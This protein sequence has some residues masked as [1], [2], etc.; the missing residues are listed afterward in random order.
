MFEVLIAI[1]VFLLLLLAGV[2]VAYASIAGAVAGLAI[3]GLLPME[4]LAQQAYVPTSSY[5]MLAIPFFILTADLL[6]SGRLGKQVIA[7]ATRIVGRFR[8]GVGMTTV[9]TNAVFAGVSGSAVADATGLGKIM[10]PW[11][12]RLGFPASYAAAVNAS[13]S[14]LGVIIPPSIPMILYAAASGVSVGAIFS[15][16]LIPGLVMAALL[17]IGCWILAFVGKYPLVRAKV[18]LKKFLI[19]LLFATPAI[20]IPIVLIRVVLFTGMATVTEV[21]AVTALYAVLIRVLL[22]RDLSW[23][24]FVKSAAESA[25]ASA[26][27]LVLIMFSSSLAWFLTI[28]EAPQQLA[29][30]VTSTFD[31]NVA[32]I[33]AMILVLTLTGMFLDMAPAILL[34][35]PILMPLAQAIGMDPIHLGILMVCTLA[36]GLYTPPVGTTLYISAAIGRVPTLKVSKKLLVFY[37][38]VYLVVLLVA[39]A[40]GLLGI[41]N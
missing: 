39:Y 20:L 35:T 13:S 38:L 16:G 9:V 8:G 27:V 34:L 1:A 33:A 22:Y 28:Q 18:S 10:I 4:S 40:P 12:K 41:P 2:P 25:A 3:L 5:S 29:L 21:S 26:I 6:F 32:I 11:T 37:A 23:K 7:L 17:M 19:D 36:I 15:A 31:S 24:T 30:M 14:V